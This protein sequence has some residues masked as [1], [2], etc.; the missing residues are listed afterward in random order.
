MKF[1]I[2]KPKYQYFLLLFYF[3]IIGFISIYNF[4]QAKNLKRA[5]IVFI[6]INTIIIFIDMILLEIINYN[7]K[8]DLHN[9]MSI[10][11]LSYALIRDII[12]G[13]LLISDQ[14][15]HIDFDKLEEMKN[16]RHIQDEK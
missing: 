1:I 4:F 13:Y 15:K 14:K 12:I 7:F 6:E 5:T 16:S 10:A 3:P 11:G 8:I 9:T 2:I